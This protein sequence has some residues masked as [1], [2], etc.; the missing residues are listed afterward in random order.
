MLD[1]APCAGRGDST[2][3][4]AP[5]R[6]LACINFLRAGS[7]GGPRS[8]PSRSPGCEGLRNDVSPPTSYS[9]FLCNPRESSLGGDMLRQVRTPCSHR[10]EMALPREVM[11]LLARCKRTFVS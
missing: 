7:S 2:A 6:R 5:A 10:N 3:A 1:E 11:A 9:S 4:E 8:W